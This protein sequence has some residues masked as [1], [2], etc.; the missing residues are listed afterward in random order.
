MFLVYG[1]VHIFE[2]V[3]NNWIT[4]DGQTLSF[5]VD[6]N[7]YKA[8]WSDIRKL[9]EIDRATPIR[10]TKLTHT[11]VFPKPLQRQSVPLVCQVFNDKTVAALKDLQGFTG[12][13]RRHHHS[14]PDNDTSINPDE[15]SE[16]IDE[17]TPQDTQECL[18]SDDALKHKVV[19]LAGHLVHKYG[20]STS[21]EEIIDDDGKKEVLNRYTLEVIRELLL[22]HS[23]RDPPETPRNEE[24]PTRLAQGHFISPVESTETRVGDGFLILGENAGTDLLFSPCPKGRAEAF[25]GGPDRLWSDL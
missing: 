6:G 1:Y 19:Y 16:L 24:M 25:G 2:N 14:H 18:R 7:E 9:Y 17:I 15:R 3:R 13:Q 8:Y 11:V 10:L 4:V 20:D 22:E 21:M 12:H 5:V 23:D